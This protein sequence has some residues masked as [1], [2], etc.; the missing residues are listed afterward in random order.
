MRLAMISDIHGNLPAL[1]AVLADID[2]RGVEAIYHLGDLVGY[3]PFPNEVVGK[4]R[5]LGLPGVVGNY[6]LA[7]AAQVE[8]PIGTYLNPVISPLAQEIYHWTRTRVRAENKSFLQSLPR[9]LHLKVKG[10]NLLLTHGSPRDIREY[11]RPTL[12]EEELAAAL[13]DTEAEVVLVGHTH[14]PMV[15]RVGEKWLINPGSVGFPKDG[16]RRAAYALMDIGEHFTVTIERVDYPVEETAREI[17]IQGLP[18]QAAEDLLYG[19]RL[20][21]PVSGVRG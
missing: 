14:R 6:D 8:D 19:R 21:K 16:D 13:K 4:I 17:V 12:S 11:L 20:K 3:N 7:V 10:W 15:R 18:F 1:G 5:E 2:R 9:R